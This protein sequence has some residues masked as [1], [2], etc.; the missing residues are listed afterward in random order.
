M[1]LILTIVGVLLILMGIVWIL[2]GFNILPV[3]FMAGKCSM[4]CMEQSSRSSALGCWLL[5]GVAAK[6]RLR[7]TTRPKDAKRYMDVTTQADERKTHPLAFV[8]C[9]PLMVY[10]L[11]TDAEPGGGFVGKING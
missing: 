6:S 1:K 9:C 2:Q 10:E 8:G 3:G 11:G 7:P 4:R 5:V